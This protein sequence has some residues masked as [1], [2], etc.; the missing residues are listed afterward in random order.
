LGVPDV[1][2]EHGTVE[3]LQKQ[4]GISSEEIYKTIQKYL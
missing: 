2:L 3:E 4:A 1:F